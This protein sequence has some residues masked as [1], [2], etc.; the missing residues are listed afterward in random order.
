M[1]R[2]EIL[3]VAGLEHTYLV[4]FEPVPEPIVPGNADLDGDGIEDSLA[5]IPY[6]A[7]DTYG[8]TAGAIATTPTDLVTF[9]RA[10]F[11]GTLL[12][13]TAVAQLT[14]R[15]AAGE[16]ALGLVSI[17]QGAWGHN[18]GAPGYQAVFVH[19]PDRGVTAALFT[20]CPTC[21][22]GTP[23]TWQVMADLLT[24]ANE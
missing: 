19:Q 20:N 12:D 14:D 13:E 23:D 1:L 22:A 6:L 17:E 16:Y 4:G 18:G 21:A 5:D 3:D 9:A 2:D 7:V 10:L 8:W 24:S 11:D 15:S